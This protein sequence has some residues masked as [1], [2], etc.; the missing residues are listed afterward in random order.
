ML[1]IAMIASLFGVPLLFQ[2]AS[3]ATLTSVSATASSSAPGVSTNYVIRFTTTN[4]IGVGTGAST[5][6]VWLDPYTN[7][8]DLTS[9]ATATDV[10][11]TGSLTQ[12]ANLA[13]CSGP[14][15]DEIYVNFIAKNQPQD[16]IEFSTCTGDIIPPG[17]IEIALVNS[18]VTNPSSTGSYV[19]RIDGTMTD[20]GDTRVAIVN[21]VTVTAVVDTNLTFTIQGVASSSVVNGGITS[22]STSATAI[23]FGILEVGASTTAAQDLTVATN[24]VNGYA[25]TVI[26][27]QNL[28]SANG[29]DIDSFQDGSEEY[30]PIAWVAPAGTLGVEATYGHFGVTSQ[31]T[32][33]PGGDE[34]GDILFAGLSSTLPRT[35]M[36][37]TGSADGVTQHIGATR[38]GY[39]AQ[40]TALQEAA[41]DYTNQLTYVCTPVF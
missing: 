18:H 30:P 3:A 25:V 20:A 2:K 36:Y 12:V 22:T 23:G 6:R 31:D 17:A 26:Q 39:R 28:T 13:A 24:A 15:T 8:F 9:L 16:Y 40:V 27:N 11:I 21:T 35:V 32:S 34:Y 38:V 1:L 10:L 41:T 33:L 19:V 37:H 7:A 4:N 29:A 14:T 5:T